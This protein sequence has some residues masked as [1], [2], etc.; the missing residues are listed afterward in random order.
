MRKGNLRLKFPRRLENYRWGNDK[1]EGLIESVERHRNE[2][3][4]IDWIA[5]SRDMGDRTADQ[6]RAHYNTLMAKEISPKG[7][8][9]AGDID[10]FSFQEQPDF[11]FGGFE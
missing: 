8:P 1:N 10:I 4:I 7:D 3:G 6:C 2:E 11:D 5:V 9:D